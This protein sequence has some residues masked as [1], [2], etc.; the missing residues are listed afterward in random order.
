MVHG[1]G[2]DLCNIN[3]MRQ[4]V[5]RRGF[6]ERVFSEEEIAYANKDSAAAQHFA[7]SFAAKEAFAK[8]TGWGI[9]K[10]GLKSC[11][12]KRT[13]TGPVFVF[14]KCVSSKLSESGIKNVFLSLSHDSGMAIAMVVLER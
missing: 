5:S 8:A 7:S 13:S 4:A 3:R 11:C 1:I 12:V 9:W 2:V 10:M 6:V 14:D